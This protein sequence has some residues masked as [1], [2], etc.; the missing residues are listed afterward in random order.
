MGLYPF[1]IETITISG[2]TLLRQ[3]SWEVTDFVLVA[4]PTNTGAI[5]V[6]SRDNS[7]NFSS[8]SGF[9]IAKG[10]SVVV[11]GRADLLNLEASGTNGDLL[12]I[13]YHR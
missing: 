5:I 8:G 10:T 12:G 1:T 2:A 3:A 13:G 9:A 7:G 6:K 4:P 11:A